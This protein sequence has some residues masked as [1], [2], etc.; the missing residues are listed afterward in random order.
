MVE[1]RVKVVGT[2][3]Y[4]PGH[5]QTAEELAPQI[6]RSAE[7]IHSRTGVA[8]RRV[9]DRPMDEMG[10]EAARQALAGGPPPDLI[11]N[12]S[13]TPLQLIPDSSVFLQRA[14]GFEG[15]PSFS[16]HATCLS[17]LVA[18]HTAAHFVAAGTYRR[19][20]VVSAEQGTSWRDPNEPESAAL[21][22]DGAAAVVLEPTPPGEHSALLAFD[23]RTWSA[24][25]DLAEFRGAGTRKPPSHPDTVR[26]DNLFQMRGPRIYKLAYRSL[27]DLLIPMVASVGRTA[28][29]IDWVVPH[30]MSGPGLEAFV[31][32]GFP[33]EKIVNL[34]PEYGNCIAASLP[35]ALAHA[36]PKFRSGDLLLLAGTGAGVSVAGAVLRW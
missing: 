6:G 1:L 4:A 19:V 25:A 12:A 30:Q 23:M 22:G 9:S 10:A 14:L 20:L 26:A 21:I 2:G 27:V 13:V 24:G 31:K 5:A 28:E 3:F 35:M 29:T 15:V 32:T 36:A 16:I 34:I 11:L 17:F 18:L 7:W 33:R 8:V